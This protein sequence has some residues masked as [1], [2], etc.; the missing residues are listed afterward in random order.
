MSVQQTPHSTENYAIG[1]GILYI[2]EWVGVTPPDELLEVGNCSSITFEPSVERL[3][4]YS[5]REEFR[6]KDKN[7]VIQRDYTLTFECDEIAAVNLNRFLMGNLS[8]GVISGMQ[9]VNAE[10]ELKF[11]SNNPV[12][13]N[14]TWEFWRGS[15]TPTGAL[16]LISEEWMMM[17]FTLEGLADT[18]NHPTSPYFDVTYS[19][20]SSSLSSSSSS[21]SS[22]SSSSSSS[23]SLSS[24]SSSSLSSSSSSSS[25]A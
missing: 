25:A 22:L 11:V 8:D 14:K 20:S 16:N 1:K 10:F 2:G 13:P 12:G 17:S 18:D 23:S 4:H 15:L 21:S 7:V 5:S 6:L 3:P 9:G 24:S 19:S